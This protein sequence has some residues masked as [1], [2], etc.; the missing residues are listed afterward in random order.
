M[1]NPYTNTADPTKGL[2][3]D[4]PRFDALWKVSARL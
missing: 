4:D 3:L 1:T 2:Y